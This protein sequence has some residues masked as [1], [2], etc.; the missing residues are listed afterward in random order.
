[1][2]VSG[3]GATQP[4][5]WLYEEFDVDRKQRCMFEVLLSN[6]WSVR[7]PFRDLD[8]LLTRTVLT[9]V[10]GAGAVREDPN[11]SRSA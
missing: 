3:R 10:N 8:Y 7:L 1:V 5:Y 11:V 2:Q 9:S 4:A 6:G